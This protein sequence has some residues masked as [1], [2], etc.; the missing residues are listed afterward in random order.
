MT[1]WYLLTVHTRAAPVKVEPEEYEDY[2]TEVS[3]LEGLAFEMHGSWNNDEDEEEREEQKEEI[4]E[5][6]D[7][8]WEELLSGDG[9][10]E[11]SGR[12]TNVRG[13]RC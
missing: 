10:V 4:K 5:L 11:E 13:G 7:E 1:V 2:G 8:F 6:N 3:E 9:I 12:A